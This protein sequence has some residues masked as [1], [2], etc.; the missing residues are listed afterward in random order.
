MSWVDKLERRFGRYGIRNLTAILVVCQA[1][2]W[3]VTM[4]FNA[5]A[6]LLVTLSRAALA[7]GQIWRL[8]T[9]LAV[10]MD[11]S[12]LGFLLSLYFLWFVGS[13]LE[14]YWGDFRYTLY[15]LLGTAGCI[16]AALLTGSCGNGYLYTSL[17][18]AFAARF[19]DAQL[20]LFFVLPVK[21]K[22]MGI[23]AGVLLVLAFF[24]AGWAG[25]VQLL[26]SLLGFLV[27]F[28][29]DL[30]RDGRAWLR[31]EQWRRQ[32]RSNWRR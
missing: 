22:W 32:N 8:V 6:Y 13:A 4:F 24:A 29:A 19:P 30:F 28:G 23:A 3:A 12:V 17:F 10:P 18:L 5:Y 11:F 20:V 27:F 2:V 1:A 9:F 7:R 16:L 14:Q 25:K 15:L 31:R 26:C 21:A